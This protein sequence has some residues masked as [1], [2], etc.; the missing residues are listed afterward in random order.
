MRASSSRLFQAT[1]TTERLD[2]CG[3]VA[4]GAHD[5]GDGGRDV[6]RFASRARGSSAPS[7][8][9]SS[10]WWPGRSGCACFGASR[11]GRGGGIIS[12]PKRLYAHTDPEGRPMKRRLPALLAALALGAGAALGVAACGDDDDETT[13]VEEVESVTTEVTETTE[14]E[15][16][17]TE[18]TTTESAT[19]PVARLA[20]ATT[21]AEAA[22]SATE[23]DSW[24]Q[25]G[26]EIVDCR[27]CPRLVEWREAVAADPPKRLPRRGVLGPAGAGIRRSPG[28]DRGRRAG[29]GRERGEP[30]GPGVHRRPLRRLA[31]RRACTGPGSRT[32]RPPST[33]TTACGCT[34]A[35]VTAVNRCPPPANRPTPAER[36]NCL[37]YL[38]RE[39]VLLRRAR[40]LVALG[41]YGWDG[42]LRALAGLGA[43]VPRPRPRF[44]HGAEAAI[45]VPG[46]RGPRSL[47]CSAASTRAS[48][49][50]S[51]AS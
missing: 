9:R 6:R 39:L 46:T 47:R 48:R 5:G 12:D 51:P 22:G 8:R 41:S 24:D 49:T 32:S 7:R 4:T 45:E 15:E 14:T 19:T 20:A 44:G 36:D 28:G 50:P 27:R 18:E 35:Y 1:I 13:T 40:V 33:A 38:E 2:A 31:L 25:L 37:P 30:D 16:T 10:G 26:R 17:T 43:E 21:R 3:S 11:T 23:R 29:A 34:G 42:S